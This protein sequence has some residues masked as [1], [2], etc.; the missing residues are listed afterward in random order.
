IVTVKPAETLDAQAL[1]KEISDRNIIISLR[2]R[3]LR[4]SPHFYHSPEDIS[5]T[6][7]AVREC[8]SEQ[9]AR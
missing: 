5:F 1:F 3:M 6:V 7:D 9:L 4:F 2:E 8:F